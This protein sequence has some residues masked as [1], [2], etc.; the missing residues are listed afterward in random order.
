MSAP[1][2]VVVAHEVKVFHSRG[3]TGSRVVEPR[4]DHSRWAHEGWNQEERAH[5]LTITKGG[6]CRLVDARV[7]T[8][9]SCKTK[10]HE[11]AKVG[12]KLKEHYYWC[13]CNGS[14]S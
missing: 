1:V 6:Q 11:T 12:D 7:C 4:R 2:C 13:F 5:R 3:E 8:D 14:D 9:G 10:Y